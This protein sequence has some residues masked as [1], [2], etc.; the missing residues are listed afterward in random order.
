MKAKISW[1]EIIDSTNNEA[2]RQINT[3]TDLSF[4]AAEYQTNGR[5]QKGN[6]WESASGKNLTFSIL[7]RPSFLFIEDQFIISQLVTLSLK[8]Y[9]FKNGL[10]VKIKWP[11]DIYC[12]D[13]KICGILIENHFSGVNLSASIA[14]IGININQSQ[15][16]SDAPNP[17]SLLLETGRD[18][19]LKEELNTF[20]D[21][22]IEK[23]LDF[24]HNINESAKENI[25]KEYTNSL[26][27]LGELCK[28]ENLKSGELFIG[29]IKGID[30]KACLIVEKESGESESF[31]FKEIKYF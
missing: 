12:G 8:K 30:N 20:V 6:K 18:Y 24:E 22:F 19:N 17:T 28:Y 14:G 5:G 7:M 2:L 23:Y 9:F 29:K 10:N 13:N 16:D 3:A 27:R 25:D 1:F 15:F 11:N 4:F 31:A 26:Y 21:I